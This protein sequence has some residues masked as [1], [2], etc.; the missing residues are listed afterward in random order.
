MTPTNADPIREQERSQMAAA[1]SGIP[2]PP[3]LMTPTSANPKLPEILSQI[4]TITGE[5]SH[6]TS[7][8]TSTSA[9]LKL[10]NA[11]S[12]V[13]NATGEFLRLTSLMT[14]TNSDRIVQPASKTES[15]LP[16][17]ATKTRGSSPLEAN[18]DKNERVT[19]YDPSGAR[20]PVNS[21]RYLNINTDIL[22]LV[23]AFE[24]VVT[25]SS[26]QSNFLKEVGDEKNEHDG[27]GEKKDKGGLSGELRRYPIYV[28]VTDPRTSM[29]L[30]NAD[31]QKGDDGTGGEGV[32]KSPFRLVKY[33]GMSPFDVDIDAIWSNFCLGEPKEGDNDGPRKE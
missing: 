10:R 31:V 5:F 16:V 9:D 27:T 2:R 28:D 26:T 13:A 4:A 15:T 17:D 12:Q 23:K 1:T 19:G 32:P 21:I 30:L 25:P 33:N 24:N 7:L 14:S 20:Q 3:S 29:M 11:L 22:P 18:A 6:Q 8:M